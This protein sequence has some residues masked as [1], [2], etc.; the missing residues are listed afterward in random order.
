MNLKELAIKHHTDKHYDH[1]YIPMYEEFMRGKRLSCTRIL[2]IGLQY[3]ASA[4]MWREYFPGSD[5]LFIDIN[6]VVTVYGITVIKGNQNDPAVWDQVP[7]ELDFVIDD[8]SHIPNDVITS[9]NLGFHKL[10][11]GG[12]WFIEDTHC[13]FHPNFSDKDVLY[14]WI[15]N[16]LM[17]QQKNISCGD[18]YKTRETLTGSN[19][20]IL[21]VHFYKSVIVIEKIKGA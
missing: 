15:F 3:G 9:F 16:I 14:P 13:N 17:E 11:N 12:L 7:N 19:R 8:G 18:F 5:I 6:P 1:N 20:D 2:E 21:S 4:R 10:K